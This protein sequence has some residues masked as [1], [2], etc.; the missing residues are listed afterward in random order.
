M[1]EFERPV[2]LPP[3]EPTAPLLTAEDVGQSLGAP[4]QAIRAGLERLAEL[5]PLPRAGKAEQRPAR[6]RPERAAGGGT[7]VAAGSAAADEELTPSAPGDPKPHRSRPGGQTAREV[8][9]QGG[10]QAQTTEARDKVI[11]EKEQRSHMAAPRSAYVQRMAAER[12]QRCWRAS[13]QYKRDR[14]EWRESAGVCATKIQ[15]RWR[16]HHV[17]KARLDKAAMAVQRHVRGYLVRLVLK[18]HTASVTIQRHVMGFLL[19]KHLSRLGAAAVEMQRLMR[20]G[21]GRRIFKQR[22][23]LLLKVAVRLQSF[24]RRIIARRLVDGKRGVR[25]VEQAKLKAAEDCQRYYRGAKGRGRFEERKREQ[26]EER[27]RDEAA[28]KI[29]SMTRRDQAKKRVHKVRSERLESM[30]KAATFVRKLWLSHITRKRYLELKREFVMHQD[31]I[32]T[33]QRYTRGFLVRLRMWR[34]AIRAEEELWA[35]VEIQ[36]VWRGHLGRLAWEYRYEQIWSREVAALRLQRHLRGWLARTRVSR[37]RKKI[38]RREFELARLRF[39]SAQKIQA[40]ARGILVRKVIG[41]WWDA[42]RRNVIAIQRV[43]RGHDLR[44][45][46]WKAVLNQRATMLNANARG[47]LVRLRR[48]RLTA[49]IIMVQRALR[50]FL[51]Q[52]KERREK[53]YEKLHAREDSAAHI[54]EKIRERQTAQAVKGIR[55]K[56]EKA[57]D[58]EL[59]RLALREVY[60]R[61]AA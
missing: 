25:L 42:I 23:Q 18:R 54:Q 48:V 61:S 16:A 58:A 55:S 8:R 39:N 32:N 47:F 36:R 27:R 51:A 37:L 12:I 46:M 17:Q 59:T 43:W 30:N 15:A 6:E 34:E 28:V 57:L 21:H 33:M 10:R 3:L 19:R 41:Q 60:A 31:S 7:A 26:A 22:Q 20:G 40:R 38:A 29:Q 13:M 53:H 14:G 56:E 1:G 50:R 2:F 44:R 11:E 4:P 35:A 24:C 9:Q 52:A 5:D 49:T 45:R